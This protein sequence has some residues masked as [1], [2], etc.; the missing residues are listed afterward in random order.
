MD[1]LSSSP[2]DMCSKISARVCDGCEKKFCA[3]CSSQLSNQLSIS[4]SG[5]WFCVFCVEHQKNLSL[6][7]GFCNGSLGKTPLSCL[8]CERN[9]CVTCTANMATRDD[10]FV[11]DP[12]RKSYSG[13][14]VEIDSPL[15]QS[16]ESDMS[17]VPSDI[18]VE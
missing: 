9:C 13:D 1:Y 8:V 7:C 4:I 5:T 16:I 6:S 14:D 2:C 10:G 17:D 12:C 3:D 15:V 11:C 18:D